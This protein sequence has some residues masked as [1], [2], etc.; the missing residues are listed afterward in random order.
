VKQCRDA[1]LQYAMLG[2]C[3]WPGNYDSLAIFKVFDDTN[4]AKEI[5]GEKHRVSLIKRAFDDF[6]KENSGRAIRREAPLEQEVLVARYRLI[7]LR[8]KDDIKDNS[9]NK[10]TLNLDLEN[11][12]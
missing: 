9:A 10:V 1:V 3:L 6:A 12:C 7:N 11:W 5:N 8:F 2:Q 4:W